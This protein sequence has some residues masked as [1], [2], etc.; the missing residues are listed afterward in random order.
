MTSNRK[1]EKSLKKIYTISSVSF[2][3]WE[4]VNHSFHHNYALKQLIRNLPPVDTHFN[5][6]NKFPFYLE[7]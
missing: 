6:K 2:L 5:S 7:E 3:N 4:H 1:C